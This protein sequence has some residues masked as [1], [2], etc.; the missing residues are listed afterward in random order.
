MMCF[1]QFVEIRVTTFPANIVEAEVP[2]N[3][4][5]QANR[6][7]HGGALVIPKADH[8]LP[9]LLG[10][11]L[12]LLFASGELQAVQVQP[13]V[14]AVKQFH[15]SR[16]IPFKEAGKQIRI[17]PSG[18]CCSGFPVVRHYFARSK[19]VIVP[20]H[21]FEEVFPAMT[22]LSSQTSQPYLNNNTFFLDA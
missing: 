11:I 7:L 13:V 20:V 17:I 9:H 4:Q 3:S 1:G 2:C 18:S 16:I 12:G 21:E 19:D 22:W 14:M 10:K 5:H 15:Q 8:P 6:I